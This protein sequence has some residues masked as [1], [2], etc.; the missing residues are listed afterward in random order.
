MH[1]VSFL[2]LLS[3]VSLGQAQLSGSVGPLTP[4]K[5]KASVKVCDITDYGAVADGKTDIGDALQEA[6]DECSTGGLIYI[7][8][9]DENYAL[10]TCMTLKHGEAVA[11]QIDGVIAR[12]TEE[13]GHM[14]V[15]QDT[16]DL[17][18]FSGN[19]EGALQGYGYKLLQ[20]GNYGPRFFR[21]KY[22]TNFSVH[23]FAT[24]DSAAYY[25]VFEECTNGEIYNLLVRGV[26]IIGATDGIDISGDNIWVHDI[27][28]S[29]G[30]ECVTVKSP[31]KNFLIESIYCNLSG[32]TAIGS[33][34]LNTSVENIEYHRL[35]M[36]QADA[37]YLK[38]HNGDG[39]VKNVL[40]DEVIVHG[41]PYPLAINAAWGADI[42]STGVKIYNL[43]FQV[44]PLIL[45]T[46]NDLSRRVSVTNVILRTG[47]VKPKVA[48]ALS[49]ALNVTRTF[50]ATISCS[51]MSTWGLQTTR[52]PNGRAQTPTA[53]APAWRRATKRQVWRPIPPRPL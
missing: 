33:L 8:P 53:L 38:T 37:C 46:Q 15:F 49:F 21:F 16:D 27:E 20:D 29:N 19:S 7:P 32:G 42:E 11:V 12:D 41:G 14:I 50:P 52:T 34:G 36:N 31:A 28:V 25:Y 26:T 30:D 48:A 17:E 39:Y 47:A 43:T 24:I 18:V 4:F 44:S 51:T 5:D 10:A 2:P 6:W 22:V 13:C 45:H 23:G 9:A 1:R 3:L 35:Y 40:W